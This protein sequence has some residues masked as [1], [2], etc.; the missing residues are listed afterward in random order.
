MDR[1]TATEI[2]NAVHVAEIEDHEALRRQVER[3]QTMSDHVSRAKAAID[4]VFSDRLCEPD[5]TIEKLEDIIE[6]AE[7]S[8]EAIRDLMRAA[9]TSDD[10]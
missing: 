9:E 8:V 2:R 1:L 10:D 3:D 6:H 7:T 4:A 5:E